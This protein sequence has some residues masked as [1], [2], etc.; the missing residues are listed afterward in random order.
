MLGPTSQEVVEGTHKFSANNYHPLPVVLTRGKDVY[1][2]DTEGREY[3][4]MLSAYSALNFGHNHPRLVDALVRQASE[5]VV[6]DIES[7]LYRCFCRVCRETGKVLLLR[8]SS[9]D[10]Q[11]SRGG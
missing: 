7:V 3:I 4:D 11:R 6:C 10:E 9:A 8:Q 2:W 1:V 5:R